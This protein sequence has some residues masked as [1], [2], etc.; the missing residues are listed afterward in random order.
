VKHEDHAETLLYT[1]DVAGTIGGL[2]EATD[3]A[4][5]EPR[6]LG[7]RRPSLEDVFLE[8]TGRALRD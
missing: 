4:G 5:L 7:I 3:A 2:L 6:N 8:L 1:S